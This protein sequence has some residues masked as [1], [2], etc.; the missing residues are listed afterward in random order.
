MRVTKKEEM[1]ME[2]T[3][4]FTTRTLKKILLILFDIMIL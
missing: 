1:T 4:N 2:L 3:L